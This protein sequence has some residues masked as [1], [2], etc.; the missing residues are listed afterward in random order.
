[1]LKAV[2]TYMR[3]WEDFNHKGLGFRVATSS[4]L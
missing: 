4:K 2:H 1:M 3:R